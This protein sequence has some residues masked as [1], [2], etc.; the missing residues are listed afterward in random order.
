MTHN[1]VDKDNVYV[2]GASMGGATAIYS[3]QYY[4][5]KLKGM[6]LCNT[7]T[8]LPNLV[9]AMSFIYKIFRP[10]ILR[11]YWPSDKRIPNLTLPIMFISGRKDEMI[12]YTMMDTLYQKA[13]KSEYKVMYEVPGG[14]HMGTW[15]T[16]REKL[17]HAMIDF[18]DRC[19]VLRVK[20]SANIV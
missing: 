5:N 9:D 8:N 18:M 20:P 4:Q 1:D 12:P 10:L 13:D 2:L 3:A 16:G 19:D 15:W 17:L 7:F 14:S 6:F 11:N